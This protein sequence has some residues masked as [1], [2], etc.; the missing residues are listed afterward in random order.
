MPFVN[1]MKGAT[2]QGRRFRIRRYS[3]FKSI[4]ATCSTILAIT[5]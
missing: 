3:R 4:P 2:A 5:E 1:F